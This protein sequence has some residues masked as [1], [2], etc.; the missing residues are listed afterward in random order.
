[1]ISIKRI[2]IPLFIALTF[3]VQTG[4][5]QLTNTSKRTIVVMGSSSAF[6]WK[7]SVQDSAWVYRLKN[8]LSYYGRGDV[9]IDIAFPGNTTFDC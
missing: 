8:D 7:S 9:L 6:G 4:Y 2:F 1:M 5:A 3:F